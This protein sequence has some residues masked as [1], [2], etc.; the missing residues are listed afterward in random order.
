M[1]GASY[2]D[3]FTRLSTP[4]SLRPYA[5]RLVQ[6]VAKHQFPGRPLAVRIYRGLRRSPISVVHE[7]RASEYR[8]LLAIDPLP[9]PSRPKPRVVLA[10]G[11]LSAGGAERQLVAFATASATLSAIEPHVVVMHEPVGA[12][13]HY[14][15]QLRAAGVPITV[16]GADARP[17]VIAAMRSQPGLADLLARLPRSLRPQLVEMACEFIRLRPDCVH[18]W[19]DS[20]N[21]WSGVAALAV[22]V[23]HIV[24]STRNV[25]PTN[26]PAWC[27]P[28]FREWYQLLLESPRVTVINN[29]RNGAE[30]YAAWI[31]CPPSRFR[32]V[33]NG[34]DPAWISRADPAAAASLRASLL[35]GGRRLV[36]G[37]FRLADEKQPLMWL[38]VARRT[39]A[40]CPGTVFFHAGDGAL[41]DDFARAG[42]DLVR[43]GSLRILGRREDVPA[44]LSASDALLHAARHEGTP[45]VLLEAAHLGCPVVATTAGGSPDAV[46]EGVTGFLRDP[47]DADGLCA[48]LVEL[49]QD[50]AR[51]AQAAAAGP[52]LVSRRFSLDGMVRET[53]ACYP[54]LGIAPSAR[55]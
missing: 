51:R 29:S 14:A 6:W 21:I 52:R 46:E 11:S 3:H 12:M 20:Q 15:P 32:V 7:R 17:E 31:G 54:F 36:G 41:A 10:I 55:A 35:G 38:E 37:V 25:N 26:F 24:L 50:E 2:D 48:S 23:P 16:A 5:S 30:D 44:L 1:S 45:N 49:L 34:I 42:D 53:L 19:L 27:V 28:W 18:A 39:V 13:G 8:E 4:F 47:S 9:A 22:G 33:L 43:A 40:A